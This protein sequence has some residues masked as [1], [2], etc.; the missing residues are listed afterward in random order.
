MELG[1]IIV[2]LRAAV[3]EIDRSIAALERQ[4]AELRLNAE[5]RLRKDAVSVASVKKCRRASA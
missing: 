1:R 3:L 4:S 2:H 5:L